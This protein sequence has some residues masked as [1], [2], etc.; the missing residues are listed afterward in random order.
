MKTVG[1]IGGVGP[2]TTSKFYLDIVLSCQKAD[3]PTK[4]AIVISSVPLSYQLEQDLI[5]KNKHSQEFIPFLKKEA[6]RLEKAGVDFIV[7]PCNSLHIFIDEIKSSVNVPVLSIIDETISF[8]NAQ[9][10]K[11]V[12]VLSTSVTARNRLYANAFTTDNIHYLA[13][14]QEQQN[15]LDH[16]I[17]NLLTG[18]GTNKDR[19]DL[20][21]IINE[22]Q[23]SQ[24]DCIIL[25]CT[26]LQ[27][28][29]PTH[30]TIK[31]FDTMKILADATTKMIL[32]D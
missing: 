31:I 7:M 6:V 23:E 12:G 18:E 8:L 1:I 27:L 14:S 21:H 30:P 25:A 13:P 22:F 15:K 4:P 28:L 32:S 2:D 5:L 10:M 16:L 26:D 11:R 20:L 24:P 17:L 19:E 3:A 29:A 9:K